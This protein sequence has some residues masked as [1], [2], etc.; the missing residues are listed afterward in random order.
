MKLN[1]LFTQPH[2]HVC[3]QKSEIQFFYISSKN[4]SQSGQLAELQ[5]SA[6]IFPFNSM[7]KCTYSR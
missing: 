1:R 3:I 6:I 5:I 7:I 4:Y 2:L